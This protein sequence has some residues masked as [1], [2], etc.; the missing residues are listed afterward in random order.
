MVCNNRWWWCWWWW[1][2]WWGW[3]CTPSLWPG[4]A[5]V[6]GQ[7]HA[8]AAVVRPV[9]SPPG[10]FAPTCRGGNGKAVVMT[11]TQTYTLWRST[12]WHRAGMQCA[13]P[14]LGTRTLWT[15][16]PRGSNYGY[17]M[18][19]VCWVKCRHEL[20]LSLYI[21]I[22]IHTY[23]YIYIH[24]FIYIYLCTYIY[25]YIYAYIYTIHVYHKAVL[26]LSLPT[27]RFQTHPLGSGLATIDP[28]RA[29]SLDG[30]FS[31]VRP[32]IWA[33]CMYSQIITCKLDWLTVSRFVS[34][35]KFDTLH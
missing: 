13:L 8:E 4:G 2:W 18:V 19:Y 17:I 3:S 34:T 27:S 15:T 21:Y 29:P 33:Y 11:A 35:T 5:W 31:F 7:G 30:Q 9:E 32:Q 12:L 1:W 16:F 25:T 28:L 6:E 14:T 10:N 24:I 20:A 26:E 23:I 22:Y